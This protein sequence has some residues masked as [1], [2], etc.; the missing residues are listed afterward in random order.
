VVVFAYTTP[1]VEDDF[2]NVDSGWPVE[3]TAGFTLSY[4][5]GAYQIELLAAPASTSRWSWGTNEYAVS[6]EADV[7][8]LAG[9]GSA[10]FAAVGC[11]ESSGNGY[12]FAV[13]AD[14]TYAIVRF[15]VGEPTV[16][17]EG[18]GR[19]AIHPLGKTNR[20]RGECRDNQADPTSLTMF[21]NGAR[22]AEVSERTETDGFSSFG[23][24]GLTAGTSAEGTVRVRFDNVLVKRLP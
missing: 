18:N 12:F 5:E 16:L 9:P 13:S 4:A 3:S 21:V 22:L 8:S 2:S 24:I 17:A 10:D 23:S 11:W 20:I 19:G 6:V 15:D 1:L 7:M 14:D